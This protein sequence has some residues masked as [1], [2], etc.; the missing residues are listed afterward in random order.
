MNQKNKPKSPEEIFANAISYLKKDI[1]RSFYLEKKKEK[2]K[3]DFKIN[4]NFVQGLI[5]V[6]FILAFVAGSF[7]GS[8]LFQKIKDFLFPQEVA[9]EQI[10]KV[11]EPQEYIPM[12]TQ[13]EA[14]INAV[15]DV[16]PSVVSI[17]ISKDMPVYEQYYEIQDFFE[18]QGL[19]QK[20]TEKQQIGGG[21]GF[22]IS[23]DGMIL[24]NKH[25][26]SDEDAEYT[27]ITNDGKRYSAKVLALDPFQDL[28]FLKIETEKEVDAN[29]GLIEKLFQV[30]KLGSSSK[31]QIGQSVITIGNA[32]GEFRNTVS[33][34]VI[35]GL[36]RSITASGGGVVETLEDVIQT[37]AAIN[38]GNSG[39]P[40]LNLRGEVIGVNVAMAQDA[41][42]IG[43]A[44]PIDKARR[45]IEQIKN[46]GIIIYPFL[47]VR[48]VMINPEVQEEMALS[49]DYGAL[50]VQGDDPNQ[51]AVVKGTAAYEAGIK[52]NDIILEVDGVKVN[53]E[54]LLS[55]LIRAHIPGDKV[56]LKILRGEE[57]I[58]FEIILGEKTS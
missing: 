20:G 37:D 8:P 31:A 56:V 52:E 57:E 43:F 6:I 38:K 25:V 47:G 14:I 30:V 53:T 16:S 23:D 28:A 12:T 5:A 15:K 22:I 33:V 26:V 21:T 1:Q 39:G 55:N 36:G 2:I 11:V 42:S 49:I 54:N 45:N 18:I 41:Q 4:K 9:V 32:L 17:I 3:K 13:E 7:W 51:E 27:I 35:S 10:E 44:I 29:G 34:G 46:T 24:T 58:L 50:I 40:L 48:Y 19:R